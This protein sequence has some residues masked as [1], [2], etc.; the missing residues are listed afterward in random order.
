MNKLD[1]VIISIAIAASFFMIG[2]S[3]GQNTVE[4]PYVDALAACRI[5]IETYKTRW[6][7]EDSTVNF[8]V[9]WLSK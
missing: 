7:R 3:V 1:Q 2:S 8:L 9:G 4:R 5:E 6:L